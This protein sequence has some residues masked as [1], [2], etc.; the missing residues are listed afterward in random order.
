[1]HIF[2]KYSLRFK[3]TNL[4][5][6]WFLASFCHGFLIPRDKY[7]CALLWL[8]YDDVNFVLFLI[9]DSSR[10][11][12]PLPAKAKFNALDFDTLLKQAQQNLKR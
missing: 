7:K 9:S 1:M 2:F 10:E 6:L 8:L 11:Y 12:D 4:I 5:P 3:K